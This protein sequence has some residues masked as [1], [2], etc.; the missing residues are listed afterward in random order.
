M[1][2]WINKK[3]LEDFLRKNGKS[4]VQTNFCAFSFDSNTLRKFIHQSADEETIEFTEP[5]PCL[6]WYGRAPFLFQLTAYLNAGINEFSIFSL[7]E[8]EPVETEWEILKDLDFPFNFLKH[9]TFIEGNKNSPYSLYSVDE[10]NLT[11]EFYRGKSE[12]DV[13]SLQKFLIAHDFSRRLFIDKSE[14][15][16]ADWLAFEGEKNI[17]RYGNKYATERFAL[18]RSKLNNSVITVYSPDIADST[19]TF[20]NGIKRN[21]KIF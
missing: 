11:F 18:Q 17:A 3:E 10:C 8:T 16:P 19:I 6:K 13:E 2:H 12:Q 1:I 9:I 15:C 20:E 4:Y 14:I 5:M 7:L 21:K